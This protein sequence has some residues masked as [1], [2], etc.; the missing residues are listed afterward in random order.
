[1]SDV[2]SAISTPLDEN[3]SSETSSKIKDLISSFET[4]LVPTTSLKYKIYDSPNGRSYSKND[5][6]NDGKLIQ[7][8]RK[9]SFNAIM[10]KF[11]SYI[12]TMPKYE[13]PNL[14]VNERLFY[15]CLLVGWDSEKPQIKFKFPKNVCFKFLANSGGIS[16]EKYFVN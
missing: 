1:M 13:R 15:C 7:K 5:C 9:L 4:Q 2:E 14:S 11:Q 8:E 3:E 12:K 10:D 6:D 16:T